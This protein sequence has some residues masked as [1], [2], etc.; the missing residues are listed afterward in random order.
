M[1]ICISN[2]VL[3]PSFYSRI[4]LLKSTKSRKEIEKDD[5]GRSGGITMF[6]LNSIYIVVEEEND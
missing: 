4:L 5:L 6:D 1:T 2:L 3:L